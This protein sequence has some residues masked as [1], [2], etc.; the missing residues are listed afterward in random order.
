V[1]TVDR[2]IE[3]FA[4]R[5]LTE[6]AGKYRAA[7]G[8]IIVVNPKTGE[9]MA[10]CS[11]PD[12]DPNNYD[13]TEDMRAFENQGIYHPYEP[14]SVFK[15][16]TMAAA[17]D[18]EKVAPDTT[19]EDKGFVMVDGWSKPIKN[20]DYESF[21]GHGAT[22]MQTVLELSLNTGAIF[23]MNQIGTK[24]FSDYIQKFG[25]GEKT[26]IELASEQAGNIRNLTAKKIKAVDAS[27]ASFGQ[28]IT[29]TPLQMVMAYAAIANGGALMKPYLVKEII[30]SDGEKIDAKPVEVRRVISERA[31][32]LIS[33]MLVNVVERGH[34]KGAAIDGYYVAGKTGTAQVATASGIYGADTIHTFIGFAPVEN[35]AFVMLVRLDKPQARYAESTAVPTFGEIA[36]FI[37]NYLKIPKERN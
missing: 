10:M 32:T 31:A 19:Y 26:G 29:V 37:L 20:S 27:V 4:C 21:G 22:N 17:L 7:G 18:Q 9:I 35:P 16:I 33:G 3:F 8:S 2:S 6:A 23:A 5:K 1:L 14:G 30:Q 36:E 25:F 13:K 12:F 11:Y 34:A 15:A 24:T 28:G